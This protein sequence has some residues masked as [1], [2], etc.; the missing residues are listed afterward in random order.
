MAGNKDF[1]II[2][3]AR[4]KTA[5]IL[6]DASDWEGSAYML[7]YVLECALKASICKTLHLTNYP[8]NTR[9]DKVDGYFM[10]HKFDQLLI[11]S[12]LEDLFSPRGPIDVFQNW[13]DFTKE[14][15]GDWPSMR[16]DKQRL[17]QFDEIKVKKLYNYLTERPS[18]I[19]TILN[20][21]KR[22]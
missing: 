19:I 10:T 5:K 4:L 20:K 1:K 21:K 16:Y 9:N 2:T 12:G 8:E 17:S 22:W 3:K 11:P 15:Q 7:G 13:S 6:I 14:Y 18:G